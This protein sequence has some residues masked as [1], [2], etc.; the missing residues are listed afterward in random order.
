M[1]EL[2]LRSFYR[3]MINVSMLQ[4]S[5]CFWFSLAGVFLP[6]IMA[7][8]QHGIVNSM[9]YVRVCSQIHRLKQLNLRANLIQFIYTHI[10]IKELCVFMHKWV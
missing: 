4:S 1:I 7:K 5:G 3:I 10:N 6:K 8:R 2:L 9:A